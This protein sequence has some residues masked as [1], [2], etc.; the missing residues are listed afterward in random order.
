M[1][2]GEI[3]FQDIDVKRV[4]LLD[5]QYIENC[6]GREKICNKITRNTCKNGL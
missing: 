4:E 1:L 5:E 6:I 3:E 2:E